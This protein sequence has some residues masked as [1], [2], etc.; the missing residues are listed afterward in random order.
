MANELA[1]VLLYYG[2]I[3]SADSPEQKIV[4]PFHEDI[5]PSMIVNLDT[6]AYFCFGCQESGDALKFVMTL[7]KKLHGLN[8]LEGCRKYYKIL[9]SKK[10]E[11]LVFHRYKK[12]KKADKQLY[13]EAYDYFHGLSKVDWTSNKLDDDVKAVRE[14]MNGRGFS[15]KTLNKVDARY[16]YNKVYPIVF[17][18]KDNGKFRGWVCRTNDPETEKKRKY[19]YNEGFHRATSL[20]GNYDDC[21]VLYLVEGYMD[22]LK[23]IQYG[24]NNVAAVL[25]WK[26]SAQH[27]EK[28]K[29]QANIKYIVS[30]LDNDSCGKKGSAY[31]RSVFPDKY[32]RFQYL[33]GIKDPGEMTERQFR[34]MLERTKDIIKSKES[35][36]L[37]KE[38]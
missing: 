5:N 10:F 29:Q 11:R 28:I 16:T 18:M 1:K 3:Y 24:V 15:N 32:V 20:V 30:A 19:L 8:D 12:V 22:R 25:G 7:E 26:L 4:C 9:K 2:L 23:F 33:K 35:A 36:R 27:I 38:K 17:P 14:Y 31:I 37:R 6:N 34:K 21:E 13:A